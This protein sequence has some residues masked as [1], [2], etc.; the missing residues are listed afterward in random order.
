MTVLTPHPGEAARLLNVSSEQVQ[1]DRLSSLE[2]LIHITQAIV[3]LKG[4]NTL[5][6]APHQGAQKCHRGNPGMGVG[7]MGDVLTGLIAA[8]VAQG[9]RHDLSVFEATGLAVELHSMAADVLV[10]QGVGPI[11]LTPME[12]ILK[13]RDLINIK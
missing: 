3:V 9:I 5:L 1:A 13:V 6:G 4:Q 8:L 7:G 10:N 2:E 11:G 12:I